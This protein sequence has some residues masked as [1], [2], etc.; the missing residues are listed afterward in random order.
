[1]VVI[2]VGVRGDQSSVRTLCGY[3]W[4]G[5]GGWRV[6]VVLMLILLYCVR[7]TF[8]FLCV[9]DNDNVFL[10]LFLGVPHT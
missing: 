1:M 6:G 8:H 2:G 4:V 7:F 9:Y 5:V 3:E 10:T